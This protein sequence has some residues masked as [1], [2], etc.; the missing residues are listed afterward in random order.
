MELKCEEVSNLWLVGR[1][2]KKGHSIL[3]QGPESRKLT[4]LE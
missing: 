4:L 3:Y 1:D 2:E